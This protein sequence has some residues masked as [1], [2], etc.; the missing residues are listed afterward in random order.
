MQAL[1]VRAVFGLCVYKLYG[2][3]NKISEP[4]TLCSWDILDPL[5]SIVFHLNAQNHYLTPHLDKC[6]NERA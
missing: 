5:A 2:R 4:G 6:Q 3:G 1:N